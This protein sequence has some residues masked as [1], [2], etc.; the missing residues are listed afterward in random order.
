MKFI[1]KYRWIWIVG[2]IVLIAAIFLSGAGLVGSGGATEEEPMET[3]VAF[4]GELTESATASGQVTAQRQATLSLAAAGLVTRVNFEVGDQVT[5]GDILVQLDT[6]ALERAVASAEA[7]VVIAEAELANLLVGATEAEVAAAEAAV[8]SARV[9][10]DELLAG[11]TAQDI[12]ASEARVN[13]AQAN[14][15]A[16]SGNR[17]AIFQV[18]ASDILAAE[19]DLEAAQEQQQAARDIWVRLADCEVNDSGTH[20]CTST[21]SDRMET[22]NRNVAA[23]DAQ[24]ALAQARLN[25]LR[26]PNANNIASAQAGL[27][28]STAQ[29]D[30]AVAR[31]E[32]LLLGASAQETAAAEADLIGAQASLDKLLAGPSETDIAIFEIRLAQAKTAL[33]E[34]SNSLEDAVLVAPFDGVITSLLVNQGEQAAGQAVILED[35]G[36]LEVILSVDEIDIGTLSTGQQATIT[37]ETWPDQELASEITAIAPSAVNSAAGIVTYEVHL[38]LPQTDLPVLVGMTANANLITANRENVLLVPNAALTADRQSGTYTVNIAGTDAEGAMTSTPVEVTVG[39][40]DNRNTQIISGL[41]EG[42]EVLLGELDAPTFTFGF[43][44]G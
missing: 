32:A 44:G 14:V 17:Q 41:A 13:A 37:L 23:A 20:S 36:S 12:A 39:L 21:D 33:Q 1:K 29:L 9:K 38:S 2:G 43:G 15:A 3:A 28:A 40:K 35:T 8:V 10:L 19:K 27:D 6:A 34:A 30:A 22:V 31:H 7:N 5:A 18:S 11:P 42:D 25:E 24:V 26:N 4:I 16:A